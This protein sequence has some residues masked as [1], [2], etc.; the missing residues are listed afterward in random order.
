MWGE[1]TKRSIPTQIHRWEFSLLNSLKV[2]LMKFGSTHLFLWSGSVVPHSNKFTSSLS[3]FY[4]TPVPA[5]ILLGNEMETHQFLVVK[6]I[7]SNIE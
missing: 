4:S 6:V 2:C 3:S 5:K 7:N 1:N